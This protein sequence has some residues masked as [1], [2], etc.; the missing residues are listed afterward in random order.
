VISQARQGI[1]AQIKANQS[2][3][4]M[5]RMGLVD[6]GFGGLMPDPMGVPV[7]Y[8]AKVRISHESKSVSNL[9]PK[10]VGLGT[11]LAR[12]ILAD[13]KTL[14]HEGDRFTYQ[15]TGWEVGVVDPLSYGSEIVGYQAPIKEA[16]IMEA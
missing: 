7:V 12:F 8:K 3:L 13:Y 16:A 1:K 6:D 10:P 14:I 4:L 2:D 11:N 9:E 15:G 5:V